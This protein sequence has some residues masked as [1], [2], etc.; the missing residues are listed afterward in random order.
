M[1][2]KAHAREM[3]WHINT[4][5]YMDVL[6]YSVVSPHPPRPCSAS[7]AVCMTSLPAHLALAG[8]IPVCWMLGASC[9]MLHLGLHYW[10]IPSQQKVLPVVYTSQGSTLPPNWKR[11]LLILCIELPFFAIFLPVDA[12]IIHL[13][14]NICVVYALLSSFCVKY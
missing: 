4:P 5:A 13:Y 10:I 7:G 9:C 12:F 1:I 11:G 8:A 14:N 3:N 2:N 6:H